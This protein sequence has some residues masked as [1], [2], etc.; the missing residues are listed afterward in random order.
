M[1][2]RPKISMR[3]RLATG[4]AAATLLAAGVGL[5][6]AQAG[7]VPPPPPMPPASDFGGKIDNK[8]MPLRPGTTMLYRGHDGGERAADKFRITNRRKTILDIR[9]RVVKDV[10]RLDGKREE[11]TFDWFAQD[12][13]GNVWYLGESSF[14]RDHGK[15]VKNDGSWKA[16]RDG[17]KAG[18]VMEAHPKVGDTY[19]QE[20]YKGHAEDVGRVLDTNASVSVP[21]GSFDHALVTRDWSLLEPGVIE[22]KHFAPGI[23]EVKSEIVKGGSE[24]LKLVSVTRD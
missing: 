20:Y 3:A 5:G 17:A 15:W 9:A 16:G 7:K 4:A 23:G 6:S 19:R 12:N 13:R 1:I 24:K 14:D 2:A 21:F 11:K 10:A 8:Y 22:H 18:I